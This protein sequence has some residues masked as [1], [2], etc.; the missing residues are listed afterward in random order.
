MGIQKIINSRLVPELCQITYK[1]S[2]ND[3]F[4]KVRIKKNT[5]KPNFSEI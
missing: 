4:E 5:T 2:S 1:Y 3:K